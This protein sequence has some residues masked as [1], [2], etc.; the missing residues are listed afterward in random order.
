MSKKKTHEQFVAEVFA[1]VKDEYTV[2]GIYK[3]TDT[4]I[5]MKHNECGNK[6]ETTPYRFIRQGRRCVKCANKRQSQ[7]MTK[8]HDQFIH[9]IKA[10]VGEEYT[11]IGK[12]SKGNKAVDIKHN[13]CGNTYK[14]QPNTFLNGSR[15]KRCASKAVT[16][17]QEQFVG[18]VFELVGEEYEVLGEYKQAHESVEFVHKTC[19]HVFSMSARGFLNGNRCPTCARESRREKLSSNTEEFKARVYEIVKDEYEVLGEYYNNHTKIK[20][21]HK[22][23]NHRYEVAP[24]NFLN[25]KGCPIC[26]TGRLTH[27][28][29]VQRIYEM[30]RCE[31]SVLSIFKTA[32]DRVT[33]KHNSCGSVYEAFASGVLSGSGCKKCYYESKRWTADEF[34]KKVKYLVGDE[35]TVLGEFRGTN[36]EVTV[37]HNSCGR[38][39]DLHPSN[40]LAGKRCSQCAGNTVKTTDM[41][42]E[43]VYKLVSDE[44]T[45]LGEYLSAKSSIEIRHNECGSTYDVQPS[46]FRT[47]KRCPVCNSSKG[48]WAITKWLR[49][50]NIKYIREGTFEDCRDLKP[51]PFDFQVFDSNNELHCVIE[52]DGIQHFEPVGYFGGE[53]AFRT[54]QLR[55]EIKNTYCKDNGIKLIRIPYN[56]F[57]EIDDILFEALIQQRFLVDSEIYIS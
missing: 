33:M 49:E 6:Y 19:G 57:S 28:K 43:E 5:Q 29:F 1:V 44:Y 37:K 31:F 13:N 50:N 56:R 51:L 8:T 54:V 46:N 40:F 41:F 18:E 45:V 22:I 25:G 27:R 52:F 39:Y 16:K 38:V 42:K 9:D 15:C 30:Y 4:N 21:V 7:R 36:T 26:N 20:M 55:D 2:L 53:E 11:V 14:V 32:N 3:G 35:Y 10:L 34:K 24:A 17:T 48:E 12:Y 47:G 23:C